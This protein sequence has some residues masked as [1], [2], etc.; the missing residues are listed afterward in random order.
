MHS[1]NLC[2][3]GKPKLQS[4]ILNQVFLS[5]Q[6]NWL[7]SERDREVVK[8]VYSMEPTLCLL[9]VYRGQ[10][11]PPVSS[12]KWPPVWRTVTIAIGK[13]EEEEHGSGT[14][15]IYAEF[16]LFLKG[17]GELVPLHWHPAW[18]CPSI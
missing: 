16:T 9:A 11:S 8:R 13:M 6:G 18:G 1:D 5:S 10:E 15:I 7:G 4:S 3:G 12:M 14:V 17:Q 2:W